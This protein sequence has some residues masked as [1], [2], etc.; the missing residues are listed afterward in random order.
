VFGRPT[1]LFLRFFLVVTC[2][3]ACWIQTAVAA[4][5]SAVGQAGPQSATWEQVFTDAHNA[6]RGRDKQ[7]AARALYRLGE[8]RLRSGKDG[9]AIQ[10]FTQVVDD[11]GQTVFAPMALARL[12]RYWREKGDD[13]R[14]NKLRER[15]L[16]DY[17]TS[18]QAQPIFRRLAYEALKRKQYA[19]AADWFD[20]AGGLDHD[21]EIA[22]EAL[23]RSAYC[24]IRLGQ[25]KRAIASLQR[26]GS[27]FRGTASWEEGVKV[28]L[29]LYAH[30]ENWDESEYVE[31]IE[32]CTEISECDGKSPVRTDVARVAAEM[33]NERGILD[34]AQRLA[35]L[36]LDSAE[37]ANAVYRAARTYADILQRRGKKGKAVGTLLSAA[38]SPQLAPWQGA[39]LRLHAA[40]LAL[41]TQDYERTRQIAQEVI[42]DFPG[43]A[44]ICA[45]AWL[46]IAYS[47]AHEGKWVD[48]GC[49][50]KAETVYRL[51]ISQ[52]SGCRRLAAIAKA[53]LAFDVLRA[54]GDFTGA[55]KL[56]REAARVVG[57]GTP[58][59]AT[60]L[61]REAG[62][63]WKLGRHDKALATLD[64]IPDCKGSDPG[65]DL[66]LVRWV[67]KANWLVSLGRFDEAEAAIVAFGKVRRDDL[68][69][70]EAW[71]MQIRAWRKHPLRLEADQLV[72]DSSSRRPQ[73]KSRPWAAVRLHAFGPVHLQ[74]R[75][76]PKYLD[77]S[78]KHLKTT[79]TGWFS[80]EWYEIRAV[81]S[82][83]LPPGR[84]TGKVRIVVDGPVPR[85]LELP[86]IVNVE[87]A[88]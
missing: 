69:S 11:Y 65:E 70:P 53:D 25:K 42:K 81:L 83:A 8:T 75:G 15:L 23:L 16:A 86:V 32:T 9:S 2:W 79:P 62:L 29:R 56:T 33:L 55:L 17:G 43:D 44:E 4:K 67:E 37:D 1:H 49:L 31:A 82:T 45:T 18:P 30:Q 80:G 22:S 12:E 27:D 58:E 78:V 68:R 51:V 3:S 50:K 6:F 41:E 54:R 85:T 71:F 21:P 73:E 84:H 72:I 57:P 28:L 24:R 63:L 77:V 60:F 87:K 13:A 76:K 10:A 66:Q 38:K 5:Q 14:A 88:H 26:L 61:H 64:S 39:R 48:E 34:G 36:A 74:L 46:K 19:E 20:R 59:Y 40:H 52:Y 7:Q 47:W 35:K